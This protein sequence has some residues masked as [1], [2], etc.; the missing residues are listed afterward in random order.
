[1]KHS[2]NTLSNTVLNAMKKVFF[3]SQ[4]TLISFAVPS[5]F[6]V[7]ITHNN[8]NTAKKQ[9]MLTNKGK[10]FLATDTEEKSG[11]IKYTPAFM[12]I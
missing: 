10:K 5:L 11:T 2:T 9:V 12:Q 7:G 3:C 1:M 4:L 8:E 6:Y